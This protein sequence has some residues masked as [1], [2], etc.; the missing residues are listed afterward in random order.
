MTEIIRCAQSTWYV[1]H[2][3]PKNRGLLGGVGLNGVTDRAT[4]HEYMTP[5]EAR[6]LAAA[7]VAVAEQVE[8]EEEEAVG[9][10]S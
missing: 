1:Q 10:A 4:L 7:L 3:T 8:Q 5:T 9:V 2:T 6:E